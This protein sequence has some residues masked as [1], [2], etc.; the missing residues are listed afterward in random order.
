MPDLP[1]G[2]RMATQ[3]DAQNAYCRYMAIARKRGY[4]VGITGSTLFGDGMDIDLIAVAAEDSDGF[5]A[6]MLAQE[7]LAH[8]DHLYFYEQEEDES[9]AAG[10]FRQKD[11]TVLDFYIVGRRPEE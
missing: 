6:A 5:S 11:G 3:R 8:K 4:T 9:M 10:V 1:D 7:F 2:C